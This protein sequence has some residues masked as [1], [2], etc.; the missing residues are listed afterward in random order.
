MS[1]INV[2]IKKCDTC[3]NDEITGPISTCAKCGADCCEIHND[4]LEY[5]IGA[6]R[7]EDPL[8]ATCANKAISRA[9]Q[10]RAGIR[11]VV[12]QQIDAAG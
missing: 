2:D 10:I 7:I 8:C 12:S 4:A 9:V 6:T 1:T 11:Q 3:D 5:G